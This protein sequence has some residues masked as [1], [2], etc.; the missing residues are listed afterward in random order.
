MP[1]INVDKPKRK[2]IIEDIVD[3][4]NFLGL[5]NDRG[6]LIELGIA[7]GFDQPTEIKHKDSLYREEYVKN[8]YELQALMLCSSVYKMPKDGDIN[9]YLS[10]EVLYSN[11]DKCL[12]KGLDV[13]ESVSN[14]LP[15]EN[16]SF[17][18]LE[19]LDDL[20]KYNVLDE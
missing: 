4:D 18:L 10:E 9:Y 1:F 8:N 11:A 2:S 13:I 14:E 3:A 16:A 19:E 12:N 20:Y 7:L 6:R 15:A 17:K 5:K